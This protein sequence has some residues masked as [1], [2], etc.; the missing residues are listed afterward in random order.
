MGRTKGQEVEAEAWFDE[1]NDILLVKIRVWEPT[2]GN[3]HHKRGLIFKMTQEYLAS[4]PSI[5][6]GMVYPHRVDTKG[7]EFVEEEKSTDTDKDK[8]CNDGLDT[9][10]CCNAPTKVVFGDI[11]VCTKCGK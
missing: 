3:P 6:E 5:A 1:N 9:S 7:L 11:R 4:L 2:P 10:M 8:I